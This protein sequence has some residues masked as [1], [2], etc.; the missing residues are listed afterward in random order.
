MKN[1]QYYANK[2]RQALGKKTEEDSFNEWLLAKYK[3]E[4]EAAEED[5][6]AKQE[7]K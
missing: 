2:K 1:K 5:T 6:A 7:E 3:S 4:H